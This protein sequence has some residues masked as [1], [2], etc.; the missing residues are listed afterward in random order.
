[1]SGIND[2]AEG[3]LSARTNSKTKNATNIFIPK[4]KEQ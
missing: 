4:N 3:V 2:A 1:M